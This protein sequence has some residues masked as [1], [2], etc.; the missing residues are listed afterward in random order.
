MKERSWLLGDSTVVELYEYQNLGV[1]KNYC[2]S[3]STNVDG[4]IEKAT[5][6]AGMIFTANFDRCKDETNTLSF[7]SKFACRLYC[8]GS[9]YFLA[10]EVFLKNANDVNVGF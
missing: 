4:N 9:S 5:T 8:L 6:K 3:F 7:G 2:S 1:F 10:T